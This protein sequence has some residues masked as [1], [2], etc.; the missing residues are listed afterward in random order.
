MANPIPLSKA[1]E[2]FAELGAIAHAGKEADEMTLAR[3]ARAARASLPNDPISAYQVFGVIAS[4]RWNVSELTDNFR[5]ALQAGGSASVN[6]NFA[7][8]LADINRYK[9]AAD[10][11]AAAANREPENLSWLRMAG[12]F[13]YSVGDWERVKTIYEKLSKR[14]DDVGEDMREIFEVVEGVEDFKIDLGTVRSTVDSAL[15]FLTSKRVRTAGFRQTLDKSVG[16]ECL[17]V[18]IMVHADENRV[19]ELDEEF[20]PILF[21][22]VERPQ[23]SSIVVSLE[24]YSS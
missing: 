13:Y 24:A 4:F 1:R 18:D 7:R 12:A 9:E 17:Y 2:A 3:C 5:L 23:L 20:T 6:G 19:R 11:Y 21:D 16:D 8:A 22:E 14:A 10:Q 15:S